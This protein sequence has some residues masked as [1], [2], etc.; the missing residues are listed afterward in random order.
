MNDRNQAP[1]AKSINTLSNIN[2]CHVFLRE[3]LKAT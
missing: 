3:I 1:T 2:S